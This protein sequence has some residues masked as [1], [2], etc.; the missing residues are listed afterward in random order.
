MFDYIRA[1]TAARRAAMPPRTRKTRAPWRRPSPLP[2]WLRTGP[3]W[4][5][6]PRCRASRSPP[7][8]RPRRRRSPRPASLRRSS[9]LLP[10]RPQS[11][12]RMPLGNP[13]RCSQRPD[14][15]G[16]RRPRDAACRFRDRGDSKLDR[17]ARRSPRRCEHTFSEPTG[18]HFLTTLRART[19]TDATVEA[20]P[21]RRCP[22]IGCGRSLL[23]SEAAMRFAG[24]FN[25]E[26]GYLAPA[27]SFIR[28][29]RIAVV[30]AAVG[31]T[32]G[33]AVVFSL[34]DRPAAEASVAARTLARPA[35]FA[36]AR[37]LAQ[38][39]AKADAGQGRSAMLSPANAAAVSPS[40]S[41]T[42]ASSTIQRPASIVALAEAP[43]ATAAA[44]AQA[45]A[46]TPLHRHCKR[47][48]P[49]GTTAARA[50]RR[51]MATRRGRWRFCVCSA[52]RHDRPLLAV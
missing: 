46:L 20:F 51:P 32:A 31:A 26:W 39:Q 17:V 50:P 13:T 33:A 44:P 29:V 1:Q 2:H 21:V 16:Q 9:K 7:S 28:T 23:A 48:G 6:R 52:P 19:G 47:S 18:Q 27:A 24:N 36:A 10:A 35:D 45:V 5:P 12:R 42:G 3:W 25:P 40:A 49:R 34:V 15:Q 11:R 43:A 14:H 38:V 41:E 4:R 22:N 37:T 8:L 30:A